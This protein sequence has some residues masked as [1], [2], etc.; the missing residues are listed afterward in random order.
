M[1]RRAGAETLLVGFT[2]YEGTAT[3]AR[4]WEAPPKRR[5][6]R[7]RARAATSTCCIGAACAARSLEP[8]GLPGDRLERGIGGVYREGEEPEV[9]YF[10]VLIHIDETHAVTALD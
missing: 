5:G 9:N 1:R 10:D 3:A 2:T 7:R 8:T 4:D 6:W